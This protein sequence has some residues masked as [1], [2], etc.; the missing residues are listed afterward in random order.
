[1]HPTEL[2]EILRVKPR[3]KSAFAA[4]LPERY[5]CLRVADNGSG[6]DAQT[7]ERIFD[8]FFTTKELGR[9]TGLGLPVVYGIVR[10]HGGWIECDIQPGAGTTFSIYLP[11]GEGPP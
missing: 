10:G 11:A 9:G 8:P 6:M 4:D 3:G 2:A 1:M 5:V 7:R